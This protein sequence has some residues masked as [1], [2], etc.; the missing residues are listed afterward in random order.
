MFGT[1][2]RMDDHMEK[3]ED[4]LTDLNFEEKMMLTLHI[5]LHIPKSFINL[6]S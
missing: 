6:N 5:T 1:F 4:E 3:I 2:Y